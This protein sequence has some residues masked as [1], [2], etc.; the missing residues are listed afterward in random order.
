MV[1]NRL[2][3]KLTVGAPGATLQAAAIRCAI[4][5]PF[6]QPAARAGVRR[7]SRC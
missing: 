7:T 6:A 2:L 1:P 3:K 4:G 5:V